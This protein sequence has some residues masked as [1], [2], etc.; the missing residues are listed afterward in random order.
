LTHD[1]N[2][3]P[4]DDER[5]EPTHAAFMIPMPEALRQQFAEAQSE[6]DRQNLANTAFRHDVHRMVKEMPEPHLVTLKGLLNIMAQTTQSIQA[7]FLEGVLVAACENRFGICPACGIKHDAE[8]DHLLNATRE[9]MQAEGEIGAP[10]QAVGQAQAQEHQ[11]GPQPGQATDDSPPAR[12]DDDDLRTTFALAEEYGL[13]Y[14]PPGSPAVL[15][16]LKP[17]GWSCDNCGA[18]YVSPQDRALKPKGVNGCSGC[19]QKA[20][21]G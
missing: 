19:Q 3:D 17:P 2:P 15:D 10:N 16:G 9:Q 7:A 1:N 6:Q 18:Q 13:S 20:A 8:F 21:W 5:D 4:S 14:Y 12:P 11:A